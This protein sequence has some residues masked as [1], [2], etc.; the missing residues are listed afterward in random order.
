MKKLTSDAFS[1]GIR[2]PR[3]EDACQTMLD[4]KRNIPFLHSAIRG[5]SFFWPL[6][7]VPA[8]VLIVKTGNPVIGLCAAYAVNSLLTILFY[9]EDKHLAECQYWRIPEKCLHAW[10]FLCGWPGALYAQQAFRHKRSKF[11]YMALFWLC[12]IA[13]VIA[14]ALLFYY[15]GPMR[16]QNSL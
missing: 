9:W 11:S 14:L 12:A 3:A 7:F 1:Q 16:A 13:N 15:M 6:A 8:L 5:L 2:R 10:E 4:A